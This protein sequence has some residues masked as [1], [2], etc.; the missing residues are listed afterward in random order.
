MC[1]RRCPR[2]GTDNFW[3]QAL[4]FIDHTGDS[5]HS[6]ELRAHVMRVPKAKASSQITA[7]DVGSAHLKTWGLPLREFKI[8]S[9]NPDS[10]MFLGPYGTQDAASMAGLFKCVLQ[11]PCGPQQSH[12]M[13]QGGPTPPKPKKEYPKRGTEKA[14]EPI[15][16]TTTTG[17]VGDTSAFQ[18]PSPAQSK[19]HALAMYQHCRVPSTIVL[20]GGKIGLPI[21]KASSSKTDDT[22]AIVTLGPQTAKRIVRVEYERMGEWPQFWHPVDFVDQQGI[23]H[24]LLTWEPTFQSPNQTGDAHV[25]KAVDAEYVL[26]MSRPPKKGEK[27]ATVI[28]PWDNFSAADNAYDPQN[29]VAPDDKQNGMG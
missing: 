5:Q 9:Y 14:K 22:V 15:T 28:M 17:K 2:S 29:M 11:L 26:Q 6:I 1:C 16:S 7:F 18:I 10:A 19:Q 20:S 21:A 24:T 23:K 13:P 3:I 12:A 25:M 4:N 8:P 27:I